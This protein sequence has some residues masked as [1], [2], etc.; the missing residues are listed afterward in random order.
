MKNMADYIAMLLISIFLLHSNILLGEDTIPLP[1]ADI[2][3]TVCY[4]D[5]KERIIT[6]DAV[7]WLGKMVDGETWSRA[8]EE[9]A[10]AMFWAIIQRSHLRK[11][12]FKNWRQFI[13]SYSQPINEKWLKT[14]DRCKE[15]Y[16]SDF[17]GKIN[18]NCSIKKIKRRAKNIDKKWNDLDLS[19][20][21][22]VIDLA[23]GNQTN[24]IPGV[25]GW[26]APKLWKKREKNG[27][28]R[29]EN[30]VYSTEIDG[31]IYFKKKKTENWTIETVRVVPAGESC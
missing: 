1:D 20:K 21:R 10:R 9:D 16:K 5:N 17:S 7:L 26:F 29:E 2:L 30:M 25:I 12:H 28:N 18:P 3:G 27:E 11:I 4:P 15:Y 14:G 19:T 6:P 31:N 24:H 13:Q 22:W 23:K 8:T